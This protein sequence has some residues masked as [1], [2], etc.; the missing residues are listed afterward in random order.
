M[1]RRVAGADGPVGNARLARGIG[2]VGDHPVGEYR[3]ALDRHAPVGLRR[4]LDR[5]LSIGIGGGAA[6]QNPGRAAIERDPRK[7]P[8]APG[9][10]PHLS[11]DPVTDLRAGHW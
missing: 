10:E 7:E 6:A 1:E 4:K 2:D 8:A 9:G 5:E 11:L 3:Q